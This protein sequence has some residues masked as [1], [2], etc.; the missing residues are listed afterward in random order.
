MAASSG[1]QLMAT[2]EF[3]WCPDNGAD[4]DVSHRTLDVQFGD[5]YKQVAGDG[6]NTRSMVWNLTFQRDQE[7]V[8]AVKAFLD[9]HGG[10]KPFFWQPPM[11]LKGL[12]IAKGYKPA[13]IG[14]R[15]HS[16][17]VT[18]EQFFRP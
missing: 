7:E 6:I 11:E 2:E 12:Y 18:F 4:G 17:Q 13:A 16:L 15:L 1:E 3:T 5:G 10:V 8:F 14:G 9:R